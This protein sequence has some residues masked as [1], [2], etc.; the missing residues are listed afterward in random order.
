MNFLI[1][2]FLTIA[3]LG[4]ASCFLPW[5][6]KNLW[7]KGLL[8]HKKGFS[9]VLFF[10][11]LVHALFSCWILLSCITLF[12]CFCVYATHFF[13]CSSC[14]Y[15]RALHYFIQV[16]CIHPFHYFG[17][18]FYSN[19]FPYIWFCVCLELRPCPL[20]HVTECGVVAYYNKFSLLWLR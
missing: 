17:V 16:F 11:T 12:Y 7:R 13:F 15:S 9:L 5:W 1:T 20:L 18:F 4:F 2:K 14:C 6:I 10:F 19:C 3:H 8:C